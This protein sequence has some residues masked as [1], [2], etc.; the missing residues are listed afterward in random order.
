LVAS[1]GILSKSFSLKRITVW[2]VVAGLSFL[3]YEQLSAQDPSFSQYY[4]NPLYLNPALAGTGECS[5]VMLNFRQQWPSLSGGFKTY[6]VSADSY[7]EPL[8]GGVGLMAY[9]DD[10]AGLV[11][12]L[13][14]S[15]IYA[16]HLRMSRSLRL[17]AGFEAAWFQQKL[18]WDQLIFSDMINY[19]DGTISQGGSGEIPPDNLTVSTIDFSGGLLLGI[20]ENYFIGF[21]THHL[22]RPVL[23]HYLNGSNP[24]YRKYTVHAGAMITISEGNRR[25]EKGKL[26]LAPNVLYQQQQMA[27]QVNAGLN[28]Q[29]YPL[30][31]GVW[32]RHNID[33][34]D[35][36]I[37]LA[38]IV[39]KS[40]KFAYSYDVTLSNLR[41]NSGGGHEL[42]MA[43]L[44]NCDVN[45]KRP[46]AIKCPEF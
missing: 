23:E 22:H 1:V 13:R 25:D 34:P 5:R 33:N 31:T 11:N 20:G 21:A 2:L 41:G 30:V 29:Y 40:Y 10:A 35:G 39:H 27:R 38:G 12:S 7:I 4:A 26:I 8:S 43:L 45:R 3:L 16:Y 32:Y 6:A 44:F 24:V 42:S 36:I 14:V 17:N 15:G 18:N 9:A 46:G 28:V 19:T 37:F